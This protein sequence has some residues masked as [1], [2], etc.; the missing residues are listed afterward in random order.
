MSKPGPKSKTIGCSRCITH[1]YARNLCK[2]CYER[3]RRRELTPEERLFLDERRALTGK[4]LTY[5][6]IALY[7]RAGVNAVRDL[8]AAI[9][10]SYTSGFMGQ[11]LKEMRACGLVTWEPGQSRTLTLTEKGRSILANYCLWPGGGVGKIE[12][13][14]SNKL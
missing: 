4:G 14:E 9:G 8:N 6:H 5:L 1:P 13:V 12:R 2:P 3:S 11:Y 10:H 7:I